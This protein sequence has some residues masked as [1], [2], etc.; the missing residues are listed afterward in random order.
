MLTFRNG[1]KCIKTLNFTHTT[2]ERCMKKTVYVCVKEKRDRRKVI[3]HHN[4]LFIFI[5][6]A[7]YMTHKVV[8]EWKNLSSNIIKSKYIII[9][10][11]VH[12]A[13]SLLNELIETAKGRKGDKT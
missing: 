5:F 3:I 7:S 12:Y 8:E 11:D 6:D 4:Y 10:I 9:S 13:T 1:L 2:V